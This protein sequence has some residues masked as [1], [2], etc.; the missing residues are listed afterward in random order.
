MPAQPRKECLMQ[1]WIEGV[2]R[3]LLRVPTGAL[4]FSSLLQELSEAG[5]GPPPEPRWLLQTIAERRESFRV[6]PFPRG[7][8]ACVR[9]VLPRAW[10]STRGASMREDPWILLLRPPE[11]GFGSAGSLAAT[12]R[13]GLAAWGRSVDDT[14]PSSIARWIRANLEGSRVLAVLV[15]RETPAG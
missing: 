13:E 6:V 1:D 10:D 5:M 3:I 12:M 4:A 7:P 9:E 8:W 15:T 14:S 11:A 2:R